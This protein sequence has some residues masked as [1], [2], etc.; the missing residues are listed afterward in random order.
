VPQAIRDV[1]RVDTLSVEIGGLQMPKIV[2]SE[3]RTLV[4]QTL[5]P[6]EVVPV[7]EVA[8]VDRSTQFS[9]KE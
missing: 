1:P 8:R 6:G 5:E 3:A 7:P 4:G 2:K 9:H